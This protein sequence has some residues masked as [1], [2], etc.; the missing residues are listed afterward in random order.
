MKTRT[1]TYTAIAAVLAIGSAVAFTSPS[2]AD[3]P[4]GGPGFASG[5][6]GGQGPQGMMGG[7]GHNS[8]MGQMMNKVGWKGRHHDGD[9]K[10]GHDDD[11]HHRGYGHHGDNAA[12]DLNL[13][14]DGV[15]KIIEGRLARHGNDRL[16]VGKV[17]IKDDK[18]II[19]EI[20]TVDDSLVS[21]LEFDR[22]TGRHQMVK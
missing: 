2:S 8:M 10:R 13:D 16:K 6:T 18:T 14:A 5:M 3:G 9:H 7:Q 17:V 11:D 4:K 21:K 19:A 15:K 1:L 20:V 22:K 12:K